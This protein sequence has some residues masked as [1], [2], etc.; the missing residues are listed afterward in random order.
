LTQPQNQKYL[1]RPAV[2]IEGRWCLNK[3]QRQWRTN[4]SFGGNANLRR[5]STTTSPFRQRRGGN[6]PVT[7][8][9]MTA[10]ALQPEFDG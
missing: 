8:W 4:S 2:E 7:F 5:Q 1:D 3:H 10:A 9:K 6:K